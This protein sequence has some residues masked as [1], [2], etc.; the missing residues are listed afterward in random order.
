MQAVVSLRLWSDIPAD[1]SAS[2]LEVEVPMPRQVQRVHCEPD[3]RS[4]GLQV[5]ILA[6]MSQSLLL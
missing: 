4:A 3:A 1:K 6:G 2:G 5:R